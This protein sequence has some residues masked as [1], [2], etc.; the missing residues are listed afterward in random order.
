MCH[1]IATI[2]VENR[3]FRLRIVLLHTEGAA[4]NVQAF[5]LGKVMFHEI[6]FYWCKLYIVPLNGVV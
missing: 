3:I 5:K 2:F 1:L 6:K 4:V